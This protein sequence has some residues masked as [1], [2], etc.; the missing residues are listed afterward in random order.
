[1][2]VA[3][4][5]LALVLGLAMIGTGIAGAV[6][7][8]PFHTTTA[9]IQVNESLTVSSNDASWALYNGQPDTGT[10]TITAYPGETKTLTL[11]VSNAGSQALGVYVS[12]TG[13]VTSDSTYYVAPANGYVPVVL[14]WV[15]DP[16]TPQGPYTS[17]ITF[18]R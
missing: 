6:G 15:V 18:L 13:G 1:M 9:N 8:F 3:T 5:A 14:T 7:T 11:Y 10:W 16:S 17:K 12:A 4:L 2:K